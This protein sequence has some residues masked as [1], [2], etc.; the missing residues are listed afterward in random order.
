[1][2][3]KKSLRSYFGDIKVYFPSF[4]SVF[5]SLFLAVAFCFVAS[6]A[7]D[8]QTA[9]CF[10]ARNSLQGLNLTPDVFRRV[11][12]GEEHCRSSVY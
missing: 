5:L 4:G 8:N 9:R 12:R 2:M 7:D 10:L 6:G 11:R 3:G 1:M